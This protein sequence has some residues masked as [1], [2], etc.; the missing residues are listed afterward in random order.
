MRRIAIPRPALWIAIAGALMLCLLFLGLGVVLFFLGPPGYDFDTVA[1]YEA[2]V[3]GYRIEIHGQGVVRSGHDLSEHG[4]G[5]ATI[6]PLGASSA[7]PIEFTFTGFEQAEF[8][9]EGLKRGQISRR[10]VEEFAAVLAS[11]GYRSLSE[12]EVRETH[13]VI[14]GVLSGPKG[15][16]MEGQSKSLRVVSTHFR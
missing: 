7:Q 6:L 14:N 9:I 15:T 5:T 1:V 4:S 10:G 3:S 2:P 11:A 13:A 12:A 16:T 8:T